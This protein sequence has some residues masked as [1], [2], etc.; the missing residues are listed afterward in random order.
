M[1]AI[2]CADYAPPEELTLSDMPTPEAGP[3]EVVIAI[4]ACGA[5]YV[6]ALMIQGLYQVKPP[7]PYLPGN[8]ISGVI[9]QVG[10]GID[11]V[12]AGDKVVAMVPYGGFATHAKANAMT[13]IPMPEQISFEQGAAFLMTYCTASYALD[14][15]AKLQP[16]ETVLVLGAGGGVG[17]A[18]VDLARAR[19]ARVIAAAASAEKRSIAEKMGAEHTIDYDREDLKARVKELG[20]ADVIVDPVGG[21]YSETAF[22]TINVGGRFLVIGFAAGS[23]PAIPLNLAL[24]KRAGI[25]GVDWGGHIRANPMNNLPIMG[26]V[27]ELIAAGK[28]NPQVS[29]TYPLAETGQALRDLLDRKVAGKAVVTID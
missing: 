29:K 11:H 21:D 20:G 12:K 1:K 6:D 17:L 3:G 18:C 26:R 13:V 22:R 19:G 23:I 4:K 10:E 2:V 28:L 27:F 16:G 8:E 5:N 7:L 24:L 9:E 15:I 14:D 25:L